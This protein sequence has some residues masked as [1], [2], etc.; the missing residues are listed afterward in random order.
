MQLHFV[1]TTISKAMGAKPTPEI[2]LDAISKIEKL[3]SARIHVQ[4]TIKIEPQ[5]AKLQVQKIAF[6]I[7]REP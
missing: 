5:S 6:K 2:R 4:K 3:Q 1:R 7:L